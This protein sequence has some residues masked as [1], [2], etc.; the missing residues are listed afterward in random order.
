MNEYILNTSSIATPPNLDAMGHWWIGALA[1]FNL[2]LEYQK[3]HD[4]T[5]ADVLSWVTTQLDL[6]TVRSILDGVTSGTVH[7]AEVHDPAIVE[8]DHH[9]EH[10]IHVATG[11]ALVQT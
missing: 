9:L 3:G 8:G 4:N 1:L 6:D 7:W 10:E 2:E 5:V 11:C